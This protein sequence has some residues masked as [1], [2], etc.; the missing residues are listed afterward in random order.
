[1]VKVV[2]EYSLTVRTDIRK[3]LIDLVVIF[4]RENFES[5]MFG[6][7]LPNY[8]L[9]IYKK[10]S[11][12]NDGLTLLEENVWKSL[13]MVQILTKLHTYI[14]CNASF[15]LRQRIRCC[16]FWLL[17]P[18]TLLSANY[19]TNAEWVQ[20]HSKRVFLFQFGREIEISQEY[21]YCADRELPL[22]QA[23]KGF[24]PPSAM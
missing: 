23:R 12:L 16:P 5:R 24:R 17:Q 20:I 14:L 1:M 18:C 11:T 15:L 4:W 21:S 7:Y 10:K 6:W 19:A 13:V 22:K 9:C 8:V 2:F 3:R